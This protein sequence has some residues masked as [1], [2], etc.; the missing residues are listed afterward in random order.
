M[1][2]STDRRAAFIKSV[3]EFMSQYSFQGVDLDWQYP[4]VRGSSTDDAAN[5]V[6]LVREMRLAWGQKYGIS[7]TLP[8]DA[9]Y[10]NRFDAKGMEPY[11]DFFGYLS[12]DL[13]PPPGGDGVVRPHTDIRDIEQATA[14]LWA[15]HLDAK[16]LNLGLSNYGRG[17]TLAD[18]KC[19]KTG[20][21]IAGPSNPGLCTNTAGLLFNIE[22]QDLIK[23]KG[24]K[25][26]TVPN[27]MSKQISWDDQWIGFDDEET[28]TQKTDWAAESCFGGTMI[29]SLDMNSGEGR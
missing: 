19:P 7:A 23:Q 21:K 10:L 15:N 5:L 24:L 17:Y 22:I 25:P 8:P 29:W 16:K 9:T 18:R 28:M 11:V 12:Y 26:E 1:T 27:T 14:A 2:S 4:S 20:C 3:G 6:A 13:P